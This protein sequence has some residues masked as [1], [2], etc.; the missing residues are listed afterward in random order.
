ML[1]L[2]GLGDPIV[3]NGTSVNF[4]LLPQCPPSVLKSRTNYSSLRKAT[5]Y[6]H[7]LAA[8]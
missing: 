1:A 5:Q 6:A 8:G 2:Q 7:L 3:N 4:T